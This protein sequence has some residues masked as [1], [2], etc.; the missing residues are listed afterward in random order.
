LLRFPDGDV[1]VCSS[2]FL[3]SFS[4]SFRRKSLLPSVI[5]LLWFH[6]AVIKDCRTAAGMHKITSSSSCSL[7]AWK[8]WRR[9]RYIV[10]L[11]CRRLLP[12][13]LYYL[14]RKENLS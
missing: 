12:K 2:S 10:S 13:L 6:S 9:C 1:A 14:K 5:D 11:L 7:F 4:C 3:F 8:L